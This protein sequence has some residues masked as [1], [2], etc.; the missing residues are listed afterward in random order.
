MA[1]LTKEEYDSE[2]TKRSKE[3]KVFLMTNIINLMTQEGAAVVCAKRRDALSFI[4]FM[5]EQISVPALTRVP[6]C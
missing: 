1:G 2:E 5:L 4:G 3:E 6:R